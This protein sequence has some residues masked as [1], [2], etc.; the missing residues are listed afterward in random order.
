VG[1]LGKQLAE[2]CADAPQHRGYA[3]DMLKILRAVIQKVA[4]INLET[5]GRVTSAQGP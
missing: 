3:K 1:K 5:I 2:Q 4:W